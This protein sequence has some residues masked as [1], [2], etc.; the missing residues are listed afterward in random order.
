MNAASKR[1]SRNLIHARRL[2]F[3]CDRNQTRHSRDFA[4]FGHGVSDVRKQQVVEHLCPLVNGLQ[5][6]ARVRQFGTVWRLFKILGCL[7]VRFVFFSLVAFQAHVLESVLI[8]KEHPVVERILGIDLMPEGNV[9]EFMSQ[10]GREACFIRQHIDKAAAEYDRVSDRE[11]LKRCRQKHTGANFRLAESDAF[12]LLG[13]GPSQSTH[14]VG[15][16]WRKGALVPESV[17]LESE[18]LAAGF[19]LRSVFERLRE[20]FIAK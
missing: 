15:E 11:R 1:K 16:G 13:G 12:S 4:V 7:G 17:N 2:Q 14:Q 18:Y 5:E 3:R 19:S 10:H 6:E 8:L 9:R 20:S